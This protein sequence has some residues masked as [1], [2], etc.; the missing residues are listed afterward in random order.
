[1]STVNAP[2]PTDPRTQAPLEPAG[3]TVAGPERGGIGKRVWWRHALGILALAWA[4]FPI[5][6]IYSAATNP[7]GTLNT[8]SL[9]PSGF[10]LANFDKLFADPARPFGSWYKNS[11]IISGVGALGAVFIG[12]AAAFA[13]S[14]LRFT[15]RRPGML[16]LLMLQMFPAM[17]AL[18]AMYITFAAIGDVIP[19]FGLNTSIG[20]ILAYLGGSMGANVWLLKGYFD[21]VPREL[22]EAAIVDGASHARIFFTMTLRLVMP[23][24]V[25]VFMLVFV[26]LYGEFMLASIFLT[27]VENQTLGVGLYGMTLGNEADRFF[28]QFAAGALL[29]SIP[30][31]VLY[32]AFQRQLVGGLTTGSVK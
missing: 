32:L 31:V 15:G 22:D 21:T 24:L 23:I 11:M 12:A 19:A 9:L 5:L 3:R 4:L 1:M 25:T 27:D 7:S 8:A 17:L 14:R 30:V 10:S 28:G 20:L 29:A 16:A 26:G 13:F 2:L 18:V 6:F